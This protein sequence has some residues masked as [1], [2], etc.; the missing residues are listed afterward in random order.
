[1]HLLA[2][3]KKDVRE[4]FSEPGPTGTLSW[5]RV[6]SA[7]ALVASLFW[8]T[9]IVLLTHVLPSLSSVTGMI[10]GPYAANKAGAAVQAHSDNPVTAETP[11][12]PDLRNLN[13]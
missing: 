6:A 9:H 5:G 1:M 11:P 8:V 2:T 7:I 4:L 12:A 3:I 10:V 13:S